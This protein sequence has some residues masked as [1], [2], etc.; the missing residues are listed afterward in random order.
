MPGEEMYDSGSL[1]TGRWDIE[2]ENGHEV[3]VEGL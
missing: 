1:S 3:M 2:W